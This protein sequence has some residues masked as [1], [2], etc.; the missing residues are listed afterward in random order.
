MVK[1]FSSIGYD[2]IINPESKEM[3]FGSCS[4]KKNLL[5]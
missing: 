1:I 5:S 2:N 3:A 4:I